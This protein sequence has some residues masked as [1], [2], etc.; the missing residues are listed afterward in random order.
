[1]CWGTF[2]KCQEIQPVIKLINAEEV[3]RAHAE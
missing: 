3:A 1:M 2:M